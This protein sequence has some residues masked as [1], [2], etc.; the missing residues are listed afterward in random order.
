MAMTLDPRTIALLDSLKASG[1]KISVEFIIADSQI[2]SEID[3][4]TKRFD[5][6]E[7]F[8]DYLH[9]LVDGEDD[10]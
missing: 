4:E 5:D 3:G 1:S 9:A 8:R 10:D 6:E 2:Q 7:T